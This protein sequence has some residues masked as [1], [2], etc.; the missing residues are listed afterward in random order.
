MFAQVSAWLSGHGAITM[1]LEDDI[2][3]F[4]QVPTLPALGKQALRVLAIGA[5]ARQLQSGAVLVLRRR[6][7][8][9]RLYRA[10]RSLRLE[11]GT[12]PEGNEVIV[13]PRHADRRAG[14]A[15]R[16]GSPATAIAKEPTVVI[17]IIAQSVPQDAGRLS[18]GGG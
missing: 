7:R 13:G 5:E 2:A 15:H 1:S 16:H 10:G 8:R 17:R 9:R 4:E 12:P 6:T 14:A 18:G 11:P 3:F